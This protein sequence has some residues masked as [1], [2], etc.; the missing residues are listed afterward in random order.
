M[1]EIVEDYP[2]LKSLNDHLIPALIVG[3][4]LIPL[5]I[6]GIVLFF[7]FFEVIEWFFP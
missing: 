3:F 1:E 2:T 4:L 7:D 5:I 6:L